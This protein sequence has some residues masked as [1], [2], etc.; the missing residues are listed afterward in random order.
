MVNGNSINDYPD[1]MSQK[2]QIAF[3]SYRSESDE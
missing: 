2:W 1:N 3:T